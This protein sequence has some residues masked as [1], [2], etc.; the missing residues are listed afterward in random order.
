MENYSKQREEIIEVLENA[1]DHPTA[2]EIYTRLKENLSTSSRS[3]VYRNLALLVNKKAILKIATPVG[4]DRYDLVRKEHNHAICLECGKVFD[5]IYPF[6][7]NEL[8]KDIYN[9]GIRKY[10]N[11]ED[12]IYDSYSCICYSYI[13]LKNIYSKKNML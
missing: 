13:F 7:F 4:P 6:D 3:T 12:A 9:A 2:E 5:F 10:I 8:K 11:C 1:Y